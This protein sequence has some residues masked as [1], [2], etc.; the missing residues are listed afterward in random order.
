MLT[1]TY[2]VFVFQSTELMLMTIIYF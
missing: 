1:P 2:K